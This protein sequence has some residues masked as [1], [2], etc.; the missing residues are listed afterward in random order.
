MAT[1]K[2]KLVSK[3]GFL[4][5]VLAKPPQTERGRG[6]LWAKGWR[7]A[8]AWV[9]KLPASSLAGL[10][11]WLL[12]FPGRGICL[13]EAKLLRP[14]GHAF[15]PSQLSR[16]QRFFLSVVA[17]HGGEAWV[18]VLGPESFLEV[19]VMPDGEIPRVKRSYFNFAS[20]PY[21]LGD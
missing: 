6:N 19:R 18:V 8:G 11:D 13:V 10:P 17:R 15:L 2:Y 21:P 4:C 16:A 12:V 14:K 20:V 5:T 9:Q 7:A 1:G 3:D